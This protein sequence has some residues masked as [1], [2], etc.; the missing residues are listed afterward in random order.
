L[1]KLTEVEEKFTEFEIANYKENW[2]VEDNEY[3]SDVYA[4]TK[5][6]GI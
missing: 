2:K 5:S 4:K 1:S 3:I 6:F